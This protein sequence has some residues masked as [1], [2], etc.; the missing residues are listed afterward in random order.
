MV[1]S[2]SGNP[3]EFC[4]PRFNSIVFNELAGDRFSITDDFSLLPG[5]A[6]EFEVKS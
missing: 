4:E 5:D 3:V 2:N 1:L 6:I